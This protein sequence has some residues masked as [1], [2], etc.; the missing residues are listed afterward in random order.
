MLVV[1]LPLALFV[2]RR[3]TKLAIVSWPMCPLGSDRHHL[4]R[5]PPDVQIL[6]EAR[7]GIVRLV[8]VLPVARDD[9]IIRVVLDEGVPR[10]LSGSLGVPLSRNQ[11][12]LALRDHPALDVLIVRH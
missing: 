4:V 11:K 1:I 12:H 5:V 7:V 10:T 3:G 2:T 6:L 9:N 8:L